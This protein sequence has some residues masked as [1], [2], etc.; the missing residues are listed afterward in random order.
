[1]KSIWSTRSIVAVAATAAIVLSTGVTSA[2]A[3]SLDTALRLPLPAGALATTSA[4]AGATYCVSAGNCTAGL[5][6][7][8][9]NATGDNPYVATQLLGKWSAPTPLLLPLNAV[10][11][12]AFI[13]G[14]TCFNSSSCTVVGGYFDGNSKQSFAAS[15][16]AGTWSRAVELPAPTLGGIGLPISL[17]CSSAVDCLAVGYVIGGIQSGFLVDSEVSGIWTSSMIARPS[18]YVSGEGL[19]SGIYC[20]SP[21]NC[22]GTGSYNSISGYVVFH[23]SESSGVWGA[24]TKIPWPGLNSPYATSLTSL[25]SM[26]CVDSQNCVGGGGVTRKGTSAFQ[27]FVVEQK[28]GVWLAA[29]FIQRP[30]GAIS[31]G[32]SYVN[33]VSCSSPGNCLVVGD[34][35]A[36][37]TRQKPFVTVER[38]GVWLRAVAPVLPV[39]A[40]AT[41]AFTDSATSVSCPTASTCEFFGTYQRSST[42]AA[43]SATWN[44]T[45]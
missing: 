21:G 8:P 41:G 31:A 19:L 35:A 30:V 42:L 44:S 39:D 6:I 33:S 32:G 23:I 20:S 9:R 40:K 5:D 22:V 27:G 29:K 17:T 45:I 37:T 1:M 2:W 4:E 36:S 25:V 3:S 18:D 16:V 10:A 15:E 11:H 26:H 34:Y 43:Y 13:F 28:A 14:V 7:R 24:I 12:D 38:N